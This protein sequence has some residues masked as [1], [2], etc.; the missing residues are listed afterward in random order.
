VLAVDVRGSGE[1][2]PRVRAF[3]SPVT[4]Y[5]PQQFRFDTCAVEAAQLG[6][7]MLA[8]RTYDVVRAMDYL[9]SRE[10]LSGRHVFLVGEGLGGVWA[11]AAAAFDRRPAGAICVGTVPSYKLIVESQYYAVRD[12][13]WVNGA[14]RDFDLPDLVGLIAPR[15]VLLI[16]PMDAMLQPLGPERCRQALRWPQE[17]YDVLG[18][19]ESL[20]LLQTVD[21]SPQAAAR[22]MTAALKSIGS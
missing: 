9:Q 8:M 13:Y 21:G 1:T 22:Q 15:P 20:Q 3:L 19:G 10:E 11:L 6:T 17:V 5:D 16:D 2:D 4:Q 14:L 12:Y 7:T 18:G